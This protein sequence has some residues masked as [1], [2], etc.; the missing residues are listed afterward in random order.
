MTGW[1]DLRAGL[2]ATGLLAALALLPALPAQGSDAGWAHHRDEAQGMS[3]S[4]P[5]ALFP[6][7]MKTDEGWRF[8]GPDAEIEISARDDAGIR[9]TSELR[10]LIVNSAGYGNLTYSPSGQSWMVA[11]GY[12]DGDIYYEKFF[13]RGGKVRAFSIRYPKAARD[14][15]DPVVER[16]EDGF[17]PW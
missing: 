9:S 17:R 7:T 13:V 5:Q 1:R 3:L 15:Y 16:L 14:I 11:S 6:E 8:A 12:R 4:Y 10:T 2:A